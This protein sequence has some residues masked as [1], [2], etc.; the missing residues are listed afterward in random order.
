MSNE[1]KHLSF[2]FRIGQDGRAAAVTTIED[3]VREELYQLILTN[4]GERLNLPEFGGG[5]RMLVFEGTDKT[6]EGLA[7]A[8]IAQALTR[9]LGHRVAI[10]GLDVSAENGE[11]DVAITYRIAGQDDSRVIRFQRA[12]G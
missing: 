10:E 4:P 2:P 1:G 6:M 11:V 12:A 7:K 9:W 8:R 3:H 5:V